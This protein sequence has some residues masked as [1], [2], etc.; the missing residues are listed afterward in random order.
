MK[1]KLI[2]MFLVV[3]GITSCSKENLD[4]EVLTADLSIPA[5]IDLKSF[6]PEKEFDNTA[7]GKYVGIFGHYSNQEL[8]GRIYVNAG[9]DTRYNAVIELLNGKEFA[10]TGN[11]T[12]RKNPNLI[13]FEG[14]SGSFEID[15]TNYLKPETNNVQINGEETDAYIVLAKTRLG[16]DPQTLLGTYVDSSDPT[17]FGNWD[18]IGSSATNT[19]TPVSFMG[20]NGTLISQ[21]IISLNISH[22]GSP[23]VIEVNM[24]SDFGAN[25]A[26]ACAPAGATLPTEDE[27]LLL[28]ITVPFVGQVGNGVTT[29]EQTS[30]VNGNACVWSLNYTSDI[31][32]FG[33]VQAPASYVADNCT[34]SLSGTWSWNGRSGTTTVQ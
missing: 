2:A 33:M 17:F 9:L 25:T 23:A 30:M 19:L 18:L 8:H 11:Y 28:D 32:V 5:I 12:S 1:I 16:V 13:Y 3:L 27:P 14:K 34:A 29:G 10:F 20:Q 6:V 7:K 22:L 26:A 31:V 24:P 21:E 15:F 4:N